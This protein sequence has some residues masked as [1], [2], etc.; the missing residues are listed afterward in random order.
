M[1]LQKIIKFA[2]RQIRRNEQTLQNLRGQKLTEHGHR[3]LGYHE[4]RIAAYETI[5]DMIEEEIEKK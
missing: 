2:K 4:G 1:D 3:S 5:I